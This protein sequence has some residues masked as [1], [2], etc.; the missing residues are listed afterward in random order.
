MLVEEIWL[1]RLCSSVFCTES[2]LGRWPTYLHEICIALVQSVVL[3]LERLAL[4]PERG[5]SALHGDF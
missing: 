4:L 5:F 2:S 3:I 1:A